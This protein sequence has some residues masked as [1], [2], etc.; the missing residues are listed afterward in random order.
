LLDAPNTTQL[1]AGR[2]SRRLCG[3]SGPTE[4][5]PAGFRNRSGARLN[6]A[7]LTRSTFE[8][9]IGGVF[10]GRTGRRAVNLTLLSVEGYEPSAAT[11]I[12][13]ARPRLT[14]SFTLTF[15]SDRPLGPA[16]ATYSLEHGAL[17]K[18]DLFMSG[19]A[20]NR[21]QFIYQAVINRLL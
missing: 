6:P 16:S 3:C 5:L 1:P 17:G 19:N 11:Q 20:D 21:G 12:A 18:F 2:D 15:N 13:Q 4:P 10:R 14:D 7:D 9:Y 8:P